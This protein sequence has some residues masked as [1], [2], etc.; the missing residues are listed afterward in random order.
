M[1]GKVSYAN[2]ASMTGLF[3]PDIGIYHPSL[4]S[5][6]AEFAGWCYGATTS[7]PQPTDGE[8]HLRSG[9]TFVGYRQANEF[10][11][12][13]ENADH[14]R[15]FIGAVMLNTASPR[16]VRGVMDDGHGHLLATVGATE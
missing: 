3:G 7:N 1:L 5:S 16:P 12:I 15:R 10:Y 8:Y 2:G 4:T 11:G 6:I 13:Y 14:T 9:D